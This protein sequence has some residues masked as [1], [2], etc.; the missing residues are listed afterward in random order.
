MDI[1]L[2]CKSPPSEPLDIPPA[3]DNVRLVTPG[4]LLFDDTSYIRGHGT[5]V[6]KGHQIASVA[7]AVTHVNRLV[8]VTP[9]RQIYEGAV[10]DTIIG[11]VTN[12]TGGRWKLDVNSQLDG[13]LRLANVQLPGGE[14]RR[15]NL[16]D[17]RCMRDL[18]AEGAL[19]CVE[20][21]KIGQDSILRLAA[22]SNKFGKL[23]QGLVVT[24]P[25][26]L[27]VQ[28]KQRMRD[29]PCGTHVIF[30]AN[31]YI[32]VSPPRQESEAA[33]TYSDDTEEVGPEVRDAMARVGNVI[34][35]LA[36][37]S[38]MLSAASVM[39]AYDASLKMA[40]MDLLKGEAQ[41]ELA[42][43]TLQYIAQARA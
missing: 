35:A 33:L 25:P 4:Q 12:I 17:E 40:A 21:Q 19:V 42:M 31:G 8:T 13:E 29:L 3:S 14:Q 34:R 15:T 27:V 1:K 20:V 30:A 18:I 2:A 22:R 32:F 11:R 39:A 7:G 24:V 36:R 23:G 43:E 16:E 26:S 41:R 37:H 5:Y 6:E 10:G 28:D 38:V 9:L